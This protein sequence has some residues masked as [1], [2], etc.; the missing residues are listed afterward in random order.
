MSRT[1]G[2]AGFLSPIHVGLNKSKSR[3]RNFAHNGSIDDLSDE[4]E[5]T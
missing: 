3:N 1:T 5:V 2:I 4:E